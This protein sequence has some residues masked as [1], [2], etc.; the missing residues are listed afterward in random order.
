MKNPSRAP[1]KEG[2]N[3]TIRAASFY[4]DYVVCYKTSSLSTS[5]SLFV[6]DF[7]SLDIFCGIV[8]WGRFAVEAMLLCC[9]NSKEMA[10][11]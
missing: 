2:K 1:E 10:D 9:G 3:K 5:Q 8:L 11:L 4:F 7:K 6:F